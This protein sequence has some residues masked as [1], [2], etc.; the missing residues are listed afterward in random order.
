[1]TLL[2]CCWLVS[3]GSSGNSSNLKCFEVHFDINRGIA[4]TNHLAAETS[5]ATILGNGTVNLES[6]RMVI[7]LVPHATTVDL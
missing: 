1:M 3:F 7:H 2:D 4:T 6:E 5:G